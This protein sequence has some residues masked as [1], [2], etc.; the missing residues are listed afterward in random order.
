ML[1]KDNKDSKTKK[2]SIL[3]RIKSVAGKVVKVK[4]KRVI[5]HGGNYEL[6]R[7]VFCN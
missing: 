4:I 7:I 6:F 3:S 5:L 2:K 1:E